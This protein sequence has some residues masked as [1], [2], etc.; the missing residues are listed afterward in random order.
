MSGDGLGFRKRGLILLW[1]KKESTSHFHMYWAQHHRNYCNLLTHTLDH[2]TYVDLKTLFPIETIFREA[3]I[4]LSKKYSIIF[5]MV[6]KAYYR[7]KEPQNTFSLD[8]FPSF[9][10]WS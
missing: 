7:G 3:I 4:L 1:Q 9:C 5:Y 6:F 2:Q 8:D 10:R